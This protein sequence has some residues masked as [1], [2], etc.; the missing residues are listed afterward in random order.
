MKFC[1]IYL[2]INTFF[3]L[4]YSLRIAPINAV[5]DKYRQANVPPLVS[6][7]FDVPQY[8]KPELNKWSEYIIANNELIKKKRKD[9]IYLKEQLYQNK[10]KR[11]ESGVL[12]PF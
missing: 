3:I 6:V 2:I 10:L 9:L 1:F 5:D 7:I 11:I 8:G 12:L 4:T